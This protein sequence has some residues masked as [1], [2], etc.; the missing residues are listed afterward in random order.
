MNTKKQQFRVKPLA[1][2][3]GLAMVLPFMISSAFAVT[4]G[5]L[6]V[7]GVVATGAASITSTSG[8]TDGN[9][10]QTGA[11]TVTVTTNNTVIDWNATN[12][13]ATLNPDT[14]GSF[15][16]FNVGPNATLTMNGSTFNVLN[17]DTTGNPSDLYG[18]II[19]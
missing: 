7:N 5:N 11:A 3:V 9:F 8:V 13:N 18:T 4:Q 2:A 1:A 15:G 19:G 12:T 6:P 14:T 17:V 10:S 16:G